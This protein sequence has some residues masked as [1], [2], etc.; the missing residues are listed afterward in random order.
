VKPKVIRVMAKMKGTPVPMVLW[1]SREERGNRA[2]AP[3]DGLAASFGDGFA[4][5]FALIG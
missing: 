4:A 2:A 3:G 1:A 5:F